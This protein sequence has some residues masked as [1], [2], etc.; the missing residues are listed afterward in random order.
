M[1]V[2]VVQASAFGNSE[3]FSDAGLAGNNTAK[4]EALDV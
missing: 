1:V 2:F 4:R 3:N